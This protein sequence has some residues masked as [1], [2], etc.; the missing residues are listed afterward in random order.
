MV[1]LP[2]RAVAANLKAPTSGSYENVVM[3]EKAGLGRSQL[4][5]DDSRGF[6]LTGLIYLPSRD[7]TFNGGS[8]LASKNLALVVNTLILNQTNWALDDNIAEISG[9]SQSQIVRLTN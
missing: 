9:G 3:F 5:F 2:P 6:Q 1:S 8:S 7:T 4:V